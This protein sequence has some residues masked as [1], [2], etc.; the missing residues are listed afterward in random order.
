[1]CTDHLASRDDKQTLSNFYCKS[2]LKIFINNATPLH[3]FIIIKFCVATKIKKTYATRSTTLLGSLNTTGDRQFLAASAEAKAHPIRAFSHHHT[4]TRSSQRK[5]THK[6]RN[7]YTPA[8]RYFTKTLAS[9]YH[10]NV[11][12]HTHHSHTGLSHSL[13]IDCHLRHFSAEAILNFL[14]HLRNWL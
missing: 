8:I 4:F 7:A 12:T 10:E 1:M 6:T 9:I 14:L 2:W 13:Q 11:H 5:H 3:Y